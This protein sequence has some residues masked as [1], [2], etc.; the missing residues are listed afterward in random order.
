MAADKFHIALI[1]P[2]RYDA[3]GYVFQWKRPAA[4]TAG[5]AVL[6]GL[7]KDCGERK[8]LGDDV[9][10]TYEGH[11]EIFGPLPFDEII[12]RI[13]E[14]GSGLVCLAG[15]I[16]SHFPR[17]IDIADI[18]LE[19]DIPVAV[20]GVH[21]GGVISLYDD[22]PLGLAEAK[23]KGVILFA[24]PAEGNMDGFL[25]DVYQGSAKPIYNY[26]NA[27]IDLRNAPMPIYPMEQVKKTFGG[28]IH[29]ET[30]RGCPFKC[31][32]CCIPNTQGNTMLQRDPDR[33]VEF[34]REYVQKGVVT[35]FMSDD[36]LVRNKEWPIFF[37]KMAKYRKTEPRFFEL[38]IET[39][40]IAYKVPGFVEKA[41]KAG[42]TDV[43]IGMESIDADTLKDCGKKHNR[44]AN[45]RD[46][47]KAW[48][49]AGCVTL[50]GFILG[51]PNDTP[52]RVLKNIDYLVEKFPG[53][54]FTV[55]VLT[56]LPGSADQK[57]LM[58]EGVALDADLNGYDLG[59][60]VFEHPTID[61][62]L[63]VSM[64]GKILGR[65]YSLKRAWNII[66]QGLLNP[67]RRVTNKTWAI[68]TTLG[69]RVSQGGAYEFGIGRYR[70]RHNR[71]PGLPVEPVLLFYPKYF[72]KDAWVIAQSGVYLAI[73]NIMVKV[74]THITDK[75]IAKRKTREE[76]DLKIS[77]E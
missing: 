52:D 30:S 77:V 36:N 68:I 69:Y 76:V 1:T 67:T 9:E 18:F 54:I 41:A 60:L 17:A 51:F 2:S 33:L 42:V 29:I 27:K 64:K 65:L 55:S 35:F 14:A 56:P 39:D 38:I 26:L 20:G 6:T 63:L 62:A 24:G 7:I 44:A 37:E 32:F 22:L 74:L 72:I 19:H 15:V 59:H 48:Y 70:L 47:F 5:L 28:F 12:R 57:R 75:E 8:I 45:H 49:E 53:E 4:L 10:I 43:F 23:D 16:S 66:R 21:V 58:E 50:S 40:T 46:M 25:R 13:R 34:I 61:K 3:D 71:R 73:I 11:Y 31:T